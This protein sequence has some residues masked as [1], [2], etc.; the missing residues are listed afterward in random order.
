MATQPQ[1]H[2]WADIPSEE[3][4]PLLQRQLVSGAQAMVARF[5]LA[6]GCI[7]PTHSHPNEQ[8]ATV[9]SGAL[10]FTCGEPG[11]TQ[12]TVVRTA[13]LLVIPA[14][15]PHSAE[16]LEDTV[17]LDIFA[18]PRQDW[19]TGQDAYLRSGLQADKPA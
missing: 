14:G 12:D 16:A 8:I 6:K 18:P 10:K 1:H 2:R 19:L 7:V 11:A 3:L 9:V 13:E 15:V 17:N 5:F 4:N